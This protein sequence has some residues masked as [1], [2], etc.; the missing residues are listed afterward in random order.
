[1]GNTHKLTFF[2]LLVPFINFSL[3][4]A[5]EFA[6]ISLP[7]DTQKIQ[8][9][10]KEAVEIKNNLSGVKPLNDKS[11][12]ISSLLSKNFGPLKLGLKVN[13]LQAQGSS[14]RF[15]LDLLDTYAILSRSEKFDDI[16]N[17]FKPS[18]EDYFINPELKQ[19]LMNFLS[20]LPKGSGQSE[21]RPDHL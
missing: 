1:M 16:T 13:P 5:K 4:N 15:D 9:E 17:S 6:S 7:S 11:K 20:K 8:V 18:K 14:V 3:A 21:N 19:E 2:L 10:F 12:K